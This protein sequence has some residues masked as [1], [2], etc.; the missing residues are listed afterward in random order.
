[1]SATDALL[2]GA[3]GDG[4]ELIRL[5]GLSARGFHGVLPEERRAGQSFVVDLLLRLRRAA[6]DDAL[7][8]TADYSA[9]AV[10]VVRLIEGEPV[11]LIETLAQRIAAMCLAF[12]AVDGVVCTV[13]KPEAPLGVP[14]TDVAVTV[15]R[16]RP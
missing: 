5:E 12:A 4:V 1:M 15:V 13:H 6:N 2:L 11:D 3:A 10:E 9:I 7:G 14:F 16:Q 8:G